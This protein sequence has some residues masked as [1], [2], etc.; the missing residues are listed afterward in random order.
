[1]CE[2]NSILKEI[3]E[4]TKKHSRLTGPPY[5][6]PPS[7]ITDFFHLA[8][9]A[10]QL[11]FQAEAVRQ[12]RARLPESK[13][14][15]GFVGGPLTLY[16]YAVDGSHKGGLESSLEGLT[17]LRTV[18]GS[19]LDSNGEEVSGIDLEALGIVEGEVITAD[20]IQSLKPSRF[21]MGSIGPLLTSATM[22]MA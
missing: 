16:C 5:T 20:Q 17:F 14:L 15:L 19:L 3:A 10:K 6:L 7:L 11:E 8:E 22:R 4:L 21:R 2:T 12:T 13:G 18:S 1:M 9:L